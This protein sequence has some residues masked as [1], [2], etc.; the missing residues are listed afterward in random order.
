MK[1][2][3]HFSFRSSDFL[4]L[5][6]ALFILLI[7]AALLPLT[8]QDYWWYVR[9]GADIAQTGSVPLV[10][11][12][13]FTRAGTPFFYQSWLSALIFWKVYETGGLPFTFLL[14]VIIVAITYGILW[15]LI[16][17]AGAGPRLASLL[18]LL[19]GLAGSNNWSF[20]P[21]LLIYPLFVITLV[22]LW[23]WQK[24]G[25][26]GLWFLPLM[27][28]VW[29]N[30]HGSFPLLFLLQLLALVFGSGDRKRLLIA[31]VVS[32]AALLINPHG[33]GVAQYVIDM[34]N[35][36]SNRY[37]LEWLPTVNRGWQAN[38]FFLWLLLFAPLA[39]FSARRLSRLEWAWFLLFGWL[40][41]YGER[42]AIWFLFLLAVNT[43]SLLSEWDQRFLDMPIRNQKTIPNIITGCLL[44][45]FPLSVLPGVRAAWWA[46]APQP[47]DGA[48]PIAATQWLSERP[49][50]NG[51]L[52]SDFSHSS[53]LIYALPSRPVWIDTRFEL[54]PV[55]QWQR[56]IEI[57]NAA[58]NW[59]AM[60]DEEGINLVM[61]ST[62][63]EPRLIQA[64]RA[65]SQWCQRFSDSNAVIFS[66]RQAGQTCG[67]E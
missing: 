20:R 49:E 30:M 58:P 66:R 12:Y 35:S 42:Y 15:W 25:A 26:R 32:C 45:L 38:L 67:A 55:E 10:D 3:D 1:D 47:Y 52:W 13:S 27:S 11:T 60:L 2:N 61:L 41:L 8:P 54:Y 33:V 16:R 17:R 36:P 4:W 6:L 62:G 21:Q 9:L 40:A 50:L 5:A 22:I 53:Y 23:R 44:F 57:S 63:G 24:G 7:I 48:H 14:R 31:F 43:A 39:A 46:G 65:S 37:S 59:Q 51:P 18:V 19:A 34:L 64:L 29:V 28:V 56:Y